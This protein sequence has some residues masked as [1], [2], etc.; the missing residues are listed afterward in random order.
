MR[1]CGWILHLL[2]PPLKMPQVIIKR[3]VFFISHFDR[4]L[5]IFKLSLQLAFNK[6]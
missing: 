1:A 6:I 4:L 5:F 3:D 2:R